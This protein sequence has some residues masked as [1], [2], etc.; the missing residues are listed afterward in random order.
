MCLETA[1]LKDEGTEDGIVVSRDEV[2]LHPFFVEDRNH[3]SEIF[4]TRARERMK[5][6]AHSDSPR[7]ERFETFSH[8]TEDDEC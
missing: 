1:G 6:V 2:E 7:P 3:F 8:D 5:K 4:K